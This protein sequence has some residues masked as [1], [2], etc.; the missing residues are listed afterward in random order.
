[1][2]KS[3]F[4]EALDIAIVM[5]WELAMTALKTITAVLTIFVMLQLFS[6]VY[7]EEIVNALLWIAERF[8]RQ[9]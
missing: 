2:G 3:I 5:I 1:M 7:Q 6:T 8:G 9:Y 4:K